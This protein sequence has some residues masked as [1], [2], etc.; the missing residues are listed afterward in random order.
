MPE[1]SNIRVSVLENNKYNSI[2][3]QQNLEWVLRKKVEKPPV[4]N[5]ELYLETSP[6]SIRKNQLILFLE[7]RREPQQKFI[8]TDIHYHL[9]KFFF[10]VLFH[11][12]FA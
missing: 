4:H 7:E 2:S 11:S 5:I 10:L 8:Q 3:R 9:S 6:K 1:N 12:A